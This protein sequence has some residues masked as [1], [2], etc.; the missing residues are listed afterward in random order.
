MREFFT[1]L[2]GMVSIPEQ[3]SGT[4]KRH[5]GP[6]MPDKP[7]I[8]K[9]R[10]PGMSTHDL[11][12]LEGPPDDPEVQALSPD[13]EAHYQ[14]EIAAT[15]DVHKPKAQQHRAGERKEHEDSHS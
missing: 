9:I 6:S 13:Y 8:K 15:E 3:L 11:V 1:G 2:P 12:D 4:E 14:R 10:V 5:P 7:S